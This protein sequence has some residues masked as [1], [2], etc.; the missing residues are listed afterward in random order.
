MSHRIGFLGAG[1]MGGALAR[2][3]IQAGLARG[4]ETILYD[5]VDGKAAALAGEVGGR[6]AGSVR[7]TLA[8]ADAIVLAVKPQNLDEI[9]PEIALCA[10]PRHLFI[11]ILA[12]SPTAKIEKAI[13]GQP[14]VIRVMP[15]T[16]ALVGLGAS[17]LA[18]GSHAS[19]A[20]LALAVELFSSV[21]VAVAVEEAQLIRARS[22]PFFSPRAFRALPDLSAIVDSLNDEVYITIDLDGIDS[23]EMPAVGTPEPAGLTWDE[24]SRILEAIAAKKRIVGF[25]LTELAPDLGPK[26]CSYAAAKLAYRLIGLAL[27]PPEGS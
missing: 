7:E 27:G 18:R 17:A 9:A 10:E 2:G 14:R 23:G 19:E 15:N 26:A 16:P 12:G 25:D 8:K 11:S 6:A 22:L 3:F 13:G 4:P 24:V 1:N 21:G 5:I 20:D